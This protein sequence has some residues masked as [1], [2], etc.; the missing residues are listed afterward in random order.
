MVELFTAQGCASC[1]AAD[2]LMAELAARPDV[3]GLTLAVDYWDGLGWTDTLALPGHAA[4]QRG[5]SEHSGRG[6]VFT[7]EMVVDGRLE[8]DGTDRVAVIAALAKAER[9]ERIGV[10]IER[11]RAMLVVNVDGKLEAPPA[12]LWL[13]RFDPS[14]T[15]T[16]DRGANA[17][18]TLRYTNVVRAWRD[19]GAYRGEPLTL[20]LADADL[21]AGAGDGLAVLVQADDGTGAILGAGLYAGA[22]AAPDG[23]N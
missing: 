16:V 21:K 7:P 10:R 1:P 3:L 12:R 22:R 11:G 15:V 17:G 6:Y 18:Q 20:A 5:Y 23:V 8:A 2:G 19:L 13:V 14:R 9:T 4:R